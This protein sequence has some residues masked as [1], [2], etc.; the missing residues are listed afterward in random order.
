MRRTTVNSFDVDRLRDVV[1]V[2]HD[3]SPVSPVEVTFAVMDRVR[4]MIG[5]D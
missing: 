3:T 1:D 4:Q 2:A 5:G